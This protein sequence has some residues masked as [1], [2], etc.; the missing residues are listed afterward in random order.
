MFRRQQVIV[1]QEA[2]AIARC[3]LDTRL[4]RGRT[5]SIGREVDTTQRKGEVLGHFGAPAAVVHHNHLDVAVGALR[6]TVQ[7]LR[8]PPRPVVRP[9]HDRHPAGRSNL[10]QRR[11]AAQVRDQ[12][13]RAPGGEVAGLQLAVGLGVAAWIRQAERPV[14]AQ[15][16]TGTHVVVAF[17][18]APIVGHRAGDSLHLGRHVHEQVGIE[19]V[20]HLV[21]ENP[22]RQIAGRGVVVLAQKRFSL[23]GSSSPAVDQSLVQGAKRRLMI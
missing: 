9:D 22:Q 19:G 8:Q 15:A 11:R 5:T 6:Q 23:L 1:V 16:S 17:Q 4:R 3:R 2:D 13:R 20:V 10:D 18:L 21:A 14:A 12:L 7:C